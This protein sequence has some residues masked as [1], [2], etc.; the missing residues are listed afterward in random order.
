MHIHT[1]TNSIETNTSMHRHTNTCRRSNLC[2]GLSHFSH[3]SQRCNC[4]LFPSGMTHP[5]SSINRPS[6]SPRV[7][8]CVYFCV[9]VIM[10]QTDWVVSNPADQLTVF[11]LASRACSRPG[12]VRRLSQ[13]EANPLWTDQCREREKV[14]AVNREREKEG[15]KVRRFAYR[16]L[17]R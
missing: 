17:G 9:F 8:V 13:T 3:F 16:P 15:C 14:W 2:W 1:L 12:W 4:G 5:K 11:Q 10:S 7:Y 6:R